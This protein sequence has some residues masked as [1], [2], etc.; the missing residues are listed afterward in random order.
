M[1]AGNGAGQRVTVWGESLRDACPAVDIVRHIA[2]M[3]KQSADAILMFE[4]AQLY[5]QPTSDNPLIVILSQ[6]P[7]PACAF[8]AGDTDIGQ[9]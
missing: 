8:P 3:R 7:H 4:M 9:S 1:I 2:L 5:Q 6:A